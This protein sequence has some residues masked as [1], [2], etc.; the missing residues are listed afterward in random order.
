MRDDVQNLQLKI[1]FA[2]NSFVNTETRI[3]AGI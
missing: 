3:L 2:D 1:D